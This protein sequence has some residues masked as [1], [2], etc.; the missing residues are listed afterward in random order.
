MTKLISSLLVLAGLGGLGL[1]VQ[2]QQPQGQ[3]LQAQAQQPQAAGAVVPGAGPAAAGGLA[4][5]DKGAAA[6]KVAMCL[7]CHNIPGY[8]ASFPEVHKVPKIGGQNAKYI[9]AALTAYRQGDRKHPTMRSV[10]ASLTDQDIADLSVFYEAQG[11]G[12]DPA[13]AQTPATPPENVAKL[14]AQSNCAS[15]H[16]ANFSSPIDPSYPKL[17]GQH[18]DYLYVALK[19]YQTTNNPHVGRNN[20]IMTGMVRP[21]THRD[22]RLMAG[23]FASLPGD[24]KTV[25]ESRFRV[26][27]S[28]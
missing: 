1:L 26:G 20:A 9:A 7:G 21:Y 11:K 4:P 14:L 22:L 6:K 2:A 23:Y 15:C 16:G 3:A 18:A 25:P 13:P 12:S 24:L 19:A 10:A 17:A 27:A 5:G 8:Q 28:D